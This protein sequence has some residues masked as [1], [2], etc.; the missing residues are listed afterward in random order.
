MSYLRVGKHEGWFSLEKA[1]IS[2][3]SSLAQMSRVI[4]KPVF[5]VSDQDDTNWAVQP[6]KMV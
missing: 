1:Q 2:H 4:R 3:I 5:W 6:Q